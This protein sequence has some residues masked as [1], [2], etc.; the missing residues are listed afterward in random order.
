MSSQ[1]AVSLSPRTEFLSLPGL[2]PY[3]EA[4]ALQLDLVEKRARDEIADTVLFVEH[5]SVVTRG[6]GLQWTGV[7]RE[8]SMPMGPLPVGMDYVEIERGGDLTWHG[9]GQLVVYP[10]MKLDGKGVAPAR[11]VA[12]YIRW[13]EALLIDVLAKY[14]VRAGAKPGATGVWVG[15]ELDRKI[16]SIGIAVR[17]WVTF[18]GIGLN[19]VNDLQPFHAISPCGFSPEVMTRLSDLAS[20]SGHWRADLEAR[21]QFSI[22][23]P[24]T[25]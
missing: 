10:I 2:T 19:V 16:A 25:I 14:D 21:F 1:H 17:K 23:S 13:M 18:H 6:R 15:E 8:R 3:A 7:A 20:V 4:Y 24:V 5:P 22:R 9:P 12:A 11:D